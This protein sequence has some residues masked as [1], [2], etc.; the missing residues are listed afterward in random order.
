VV[1]DLFAPWFGHLPARA[2]LAIGGVWLLLTILFELGMGIPLFHFPPSRML[3][4]FNVAKDGLFPFAL[5]F[6][7]F[8]RGSSCDPSACNLVTQIIA[9]FNPSIPLKRM[10]PP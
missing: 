2:L 5:L 4:D 3:G 10:L 8:V 9:G 6:L 7:L 1:V